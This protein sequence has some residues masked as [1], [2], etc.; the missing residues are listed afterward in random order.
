M[1]AEIV[2]RRMNEATKVVDPSTTNRTARI[3]GVL[4]AIVAVTMIVLDGFSSFETDPVYIGL[5]LA[6][7]GVML[8]I[9][10]VRNV[11]SDGGSKWVVPEVT[12]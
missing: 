6:N 7:T 1:V 4:F 2:W 9:P 12:E 10:T 5:L 8:G 11:M 3:L